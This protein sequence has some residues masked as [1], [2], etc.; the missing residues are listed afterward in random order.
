MSSESRLSQTRHNRDSTPN[1]DRRIARTRA[2]LRDA[3]MA[4]IVERGFEAITVQ[5]I[6]DRADVNRATFYLHFK[7]K[8]ELL[9][10][11]MEEIYEG[12]VS[13]IR[14]DDPTPEQI[15][16]GEWQSFDGSEDWEHVAAHID[17]YRVL[18][19]ERGS[20]SFVVKVRR[21]LAK[22]VADELD[23]TLKA[24]NITP[25]IPLDVIGYSFAGAQ[26]GL[27][28]WWIENDM[29]YPPEQMGRMLFDLM[30]Q[31]FVKALGIAP[32]TA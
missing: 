5:D 29:P 12:L 22:V 10:Q 30:E 25:S 4:L 9:Y 15:A 3:L 7:D 6:V 27:I 20:A 19:S 2:A 13:A 26:I 1:R 32:Q 11:S 23:R 17:F 21:Y 14:C 24:L 16:R 18:L 31:G 8:D 28:T